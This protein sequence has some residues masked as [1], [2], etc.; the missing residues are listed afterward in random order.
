MAKVPVRLTKSFNL[1]VG[2]TRE[3]GA[4]ALLEAA[5]EILDV[6]LERVPRDSEQ[7][8]DTGAII[9]NPENPLEVVISF[10]DTQ[11]LHD[12][13]QPASEYAVRQHEDLS[14]KHPQGGEAKFLEKPVDEAEA[15]FLA[16]LA[17]H[18]GD[19]LK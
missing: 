4:A 17:K 1:P 14:L 5:K 6:A 12:N 18:V 7:L 11:L 19:A 13:D 10:G 2:A 3:A 8:A 16:I 9:E 15:R